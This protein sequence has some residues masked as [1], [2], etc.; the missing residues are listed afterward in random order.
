MDTREADICVIAFPSSSRAFFRT[1]EN[2]R[3]L[4]ASETSGLAGQV[5]AC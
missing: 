5:T 4:P 3:K 1:V 2:N